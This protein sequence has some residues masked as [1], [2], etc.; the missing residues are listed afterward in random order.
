MVAY[1]EW[2][3]ILPRPGV[4]P[5]S[6]RP[7]RDVLTTGPSKH[8]PVF[9]FYF[10]ACIRATPKGACKVHPDWSFCNA[11]KTSQRK[12]FPKYNALC[13]P[14]DRVYRNTW[15]DLCKWTSSS[16]TRYI[17]WNPYRI[18][19]ETSERGLL[20]GPGE[21]RSQFFWWRHGWG[22]PL[23][24]IWR[25][26]TSRHVCRFSL[27]LTLAL[28]W[29]ASKPEVIRR[30]EEEGEVKKRIK[31]VV[32]VSW[33]LVLFAWS[34][35]RSWDTLMLCFRCIS[36][37]WEDWGSWEG[38]W[39]DVCV[40][41]KKTKGINFTGTCCILKENFLRRCWLYLIVWIVRNSSDLQMKRNFLKCW[42]G[43]YFCLRTLLIF[44]LCRPKPLCRHHFLKCSFL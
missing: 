9:T 28:G 2:K 24:L 35:G 7:Q 12:V 44:I 40:G 1:R 6:S 5:E 42:T 23:S 31:E 15:C 26:D 34:H 37:G 43:H 39:W 32:K 13:N 25:H 17:D 14:S 10:L 21:P 3:K 29:F 33:S 19:R 20:Y 38:K 22:Y 16:H 27:Y 41:K 4:E 30:R 11:D 36:C 8:L 18:W